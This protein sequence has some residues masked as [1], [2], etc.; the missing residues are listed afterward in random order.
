MFGQQIESRPAFPFGSVFWLAI[1]LVFAGL[2]AW[3]LNAHFLVFAVMPLAIAAALL[4]MRERRFV[5]QITD[6]AFEIEIPPL[7]LPFA[8][9]DQVEMA[10]KPGK[11][12]AVIQ[13]WH[14]GG[15]TRIPPRLNVPSDELFRFLLEQMPATQCRDLPAVLER[16]CGLQKTLHRAQRV[17]HIAPAPPDRLAVDARQ[18]PSAWPAHWRVAFGLGLALLSRPTEVLGSYGAAWHLAHP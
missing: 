12:R 9:M 16:Y 11:A 15:V 8:A 13:V 3:N 10:G 7:S 5:G 6:N 2:A 4:V 18:W 17:S 14:E 1:A